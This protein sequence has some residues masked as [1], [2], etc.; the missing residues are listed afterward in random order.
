MKTS[1]IHKLT[2]LTD[3]AILLA[4]P[5]TFAQTKSAKIDALVGQY[6]ANRQFNGTVLVAEKGK[7]IFK[8]GYGMAN[9]E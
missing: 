3:I 1:L 8:K 9:M 7:V 4:T 6:V 5:A 2:S